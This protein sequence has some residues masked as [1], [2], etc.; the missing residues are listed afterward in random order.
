MV[1]AAVVGAVGEEEVAVALQDV[2][3]A[4]VVGTCREALVQYR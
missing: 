4:V 1:A 3:V 2:E